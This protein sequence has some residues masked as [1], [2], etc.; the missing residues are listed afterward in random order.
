M[1][2]SFF[3]ANDAVVAIATMS[4]ARKK[5]L[6]ASPLPLNPDLAPLLDGAIL[7]VIITL[8]DHGARAYGRLDAPTARA[9]H[10]LQYVHSLQ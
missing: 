9:E 10:R 2:V 1:G 8:L 4:N 7:E 5:L 3:F 6:T